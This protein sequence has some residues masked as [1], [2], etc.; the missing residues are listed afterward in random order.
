[1]RKI[2]NY[3]T[4]RPSDTWLHIIAG[5]IVAII[6]GKLAGG[7]VGLIVGCLAG[8]VK[9]LADSLPNIRGSVEFRD[10]L[11]TIIGAVAGTLAVIL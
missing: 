7:I 11:N 8:V 5:A 1:M 2:W 9:E 4:S 3:I 6:V 10:L